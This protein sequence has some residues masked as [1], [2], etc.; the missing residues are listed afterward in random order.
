MIISDFD[1]S[2]VA[3]LQYECIENG[4]LKIMPSSFY[5]KYDQKEIS[6]FCLLNGLYCLPTT[7]LLDLLNALIME[8]SPSRNAIE[9][10]SG[11]GSL[12]KG[13]GIPSTDSFLQDDPSIKAH[14]RNLGQPTITYGKHVIKIDA[15]KAVSEMKP[16]VVVGAWVTHRF[17]EKEPERGGNAFGV[18][19]DTIIS[20]VNRYIIIGNKAVHGLKPVMNKVSKV[21]E[22]D[23]LF[24]RSLQNAGQEAIFIWD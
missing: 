12:G 24:S 13:L 18:D 16:D 1:K 17:D 3:D 8:R 23:F 20:Q 2:K 9:I 14:Y 5:R 10:G 7:E 22:G 6:V 11:N 15:N 19:E 4:N 21:I